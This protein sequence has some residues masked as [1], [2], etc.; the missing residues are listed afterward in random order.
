MDEIYYAWIQ[1]NH[2]CRTSMHIAV[3]YG[4]TKLLEPIPR[5]HWPCICG[6]VVIFYT[7]L[8][9]LTN[10][11]DSKGVPINVGI[12]TNQWSNGCKKMNRNEANKWDMVHNLSYVKQHKTL[13]HLTSMM[14]VLRLDCDQ[15]L[16]STPE[17]E[18][19]HFFLLNSR[20]FF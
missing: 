18:S 7:A 12:G 9:P 13:P 14:N 1:A 10:R 4:S 6:S 3:P 11:M 17:M 19:D 20:H 15:Q 5:G 2:A 8:P 16:H